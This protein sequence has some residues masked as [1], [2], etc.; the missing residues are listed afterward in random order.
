MQNLATNGFVSYPGQLG[1][2]MEGKATQWVR[3]ALYDCDGELI[4]RKIYNQMKQPLTCG[5]G[6][7]FWFG[8]PVKFY[9]WRELI[10]GQLTSILDGAVVIRESPRITKT[11][12]ISTAMLQYLLFVQMKPLID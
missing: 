1:D 8:E 3:K 6:F 7:I 4:I 2:N 10:V 11:R 12:E 9:S 5:P